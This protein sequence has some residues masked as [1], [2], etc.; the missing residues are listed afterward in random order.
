[1]PRRRRRGSAWAQ[2]SIWRTCVD[3]RAYCVAL[4][5]HTT[6]QGYGDHGMMGTRIANVETDPSII[7]LPAYL[8]LNRAAL[9]LSLY[10]PPLQLTSA[11][12]PRNVAS[13][14]MRMHPE[15]PGLIALCNVLDV[16]ANIGAGN[17]TCS[18][19]TSVNLQ[20]RR[21]H[22]HPRGV[23]QEAYAPRCSV[24]RALVRLDPTIDGLQIA[25]ECG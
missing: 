21:H 11:L 5:A 4:G 22:R 15:K 2:F 18:C 19:L 7:T 23:A 6:G 20:R 8:Q 10:H 12:A 1:M 17:I 13:T 16:Y 3:L 9:I 14:P 25:R 24:F